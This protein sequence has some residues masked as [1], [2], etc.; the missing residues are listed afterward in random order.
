M[1]HPAQIAARHP[2]RPALIMAEG[3]EVLTYGMLAE[4]AN[5]AAHLFRELGLRRGDTV[6]FLL[7]N[8]I[9]YPELCWAAKEAGL[10]YVCVSTQLTLDDLV[11]LVRNSG[12]RLLVSSAALAER[13]NALAAR[14]EGT[15][16]LL[17][18]DGARPPFASYE[19]ALVRQPST[20][21]PDRTRGASMLYSSGTT[22]RPKGVKVPLTDAPPEEPPRR[23][24][25]LERDFG[26]REGM[27]FVNPGPF[28]HAAPLRMMMAVQRLGGTAI[29]FRAF[30]PLATLAAI[31]RYRATHGFFVPTMFI[32]MLRLAEAERRRYD[33]SSMEAT[34]HGG[35]PCAPSVKQAMIDWWGP[36][37][38]EV[39]GGTE[40]LGYATISPEE[41]LAHPGSVGRPAA[42][43][44]LRILD[45][46]GTVLGPGRTGRVFFN[47]GYRFA[48]HGDSGGDAPTHDAEGFAT[49]GDVGY[50]DEDG[51][52]YLT[53]RYANMIVSG[54]VNIY[55]QEAENVLIGHPMV[56]D[57]A[58]IGVPDEE[59]GEQVKAVVVP[60]T[61]PADPDALAAELVAYC[62]ARLSP[63][64][65][66][67]SV[68]FAAELPRSDAGKLLKRVLKERYWAGHASFIL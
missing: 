19:E 53:D 59:F 9:R 24:A 66:P 29:G 42:G 26:F 63:I 21:L 60:R 23:Q 7:E 4:R 55:P 49:F 1:S 51:Y 58:V 11:Y 14:L 10:Y 18:V 48:Y 13:A 34:V 30:D 39:Y 28:Y 40:G 20:P 31:E 68:D 52:L 45:E 57:V 47:N 3:G 54:G 56:G 17:M 25:L 44:R 15:L 16:S 2:D 33:L 35:A 67:R 27:V 62:R 37:I 46:D 64:K 50:V 6:A 22:G 43:S 32:R 8:H 12:A 65:C 38:Y 41:W 61:P 36:V 5:R